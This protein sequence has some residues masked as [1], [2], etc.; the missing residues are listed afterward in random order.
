[1][2]I[3]SAQEI[4]EEIRQGRM[5]ILM[6]DE[7]RENEGDLIIAAEHVTPE[8]INFMATHGRG[9]ICLTLSKARCK[10]LGLGPMVQDNGAQFSTAFTASIEA[11]H[12]VTTG[13]SAA[14]RATT[15]LAA[16]AKNAQA[17]DVVQ[18]GHVFPLM[19]QDGGVLTRAGHT[20][21]G[22]DLARLAGFEPAS[23]IVE[24][25]NDDGTM[26]RR[27]D[28]ELFAQKH[29][30]K[31]GTIADLIEYRNLH[32][33]TIERVEKC[34]LTTEFGQFEL[35]TYRDTV[36]DQ[37]HYALQRGE[38]NEQPTLVRVHVHD[39]FGDILHSQREISSHWS[40]AQA[41]QKVAAEGG[42][43]VILTRPDSNDFIINKLRRFAAQDNQ[44][45]VAPLAGN[46]QRASRSI[47]IGS[48]ILAD[49][50]VRKMRLL[51]SSDKHY[52]ALAGFGLDVVEYIVKS[53]S[54]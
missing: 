10:T 43:V 48:Q 46:Q 52:H 53:E 51:V 33:S 16:V 38:I 8:I 45:S 30:L 34:Q 39:L 5:V 6:D 37:L 42:V 14:D 2:A 24:I 23:V 54:Q 7:D 27:P 29:G 9:L 35:I 26:A 12:G 11:A 28:L 49:L 40:I 21:A 20:E 36:E 15:I 1:M 44:Q 4:I 25:L 17:C 3:S 18:P 22:C 50:G 31:L 41:M 19:A 32:E 47:G 13:I